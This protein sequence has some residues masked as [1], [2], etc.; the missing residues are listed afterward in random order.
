[1]RVWL[2]PAL[3]AGAGLL[4]LGWAQLSGVARENQLLQL[5]NLGK[6]FYEN[7]TTQAQAVGEFRKALAL[8]PNSPVER[9]NYALSLLRAGK[10]ADGI[11]ELEKVQKQDPG[12]P[13]TWFN[14]GL[15]YK[16]SG[17]HDKSI[18]QFEG[19][20]KLVP[21]EPVSHYNLGV[22]YKVTGRIPEALAQFETALRLDGNLAA[23]HFQLYNAY[24]QSG[25][26]EEAARELQAFQSIKKRTEGAA[27]P[28]DMEWSAYAEILDVIEPRTSL[29]AAPPADLKFED[30]KLAGTADPVTAQ[31]A[32]FDLDGN[33]KPSLMIW[34]SQGIRVYRNGTEV[35]EQPALAG[36]K[37]VN[38][39][40]AGDFDNDGFPDLAVIADGKP[41]LFKNVKG[42]FQRFEANLP[43]G[44]YSQALWLDYDH[45]YDQ[46]LI[47][48]GDN[49]TV[50]RNEGSNAFSE[51]P[52]D[53]PFVKGK[54]IAGATFRLIADT[55][56]TD[57]LVSYADRPGALYRDLLQGVFKEQDVASLPS[58]AR[59][60]RPYDFDNDSYIDVAFLNG[61]EVKTLANR[62]GTLEAGAAT[63]RGGGFVFADLE[64]KGLADLVT[65][66]GVSRNSGMGRFSASQPRFGHGVAWT[67]ADFD[68]DDRIDLAGVYADG[69]I[70]LL[71]NTTVTRNTWIRVRIDG[72]K[73]TKLAA[74]AEVE[75]KAGP[76]YQKILYDGMPLLFGLRDVKEAETVRI[77]WPNGLIQNEA[78]Q[79]AGKAYDYK[80]A[81]RLSGSC[82]II[83]TWNGTGFEYITDVLGVAPL[84][85]SNGDGQ[86]FPVDHQEYV[87]IAGSQLRPEGGWYQVR[88]TEELSEASYIDQVR[89]LAIDHPANVDI[90][91]NDK[92]TG[93]PPWPEFRLWGTKSR[94]YPK[95]ARDDSGNDVRPKLLAKDRTYPDAF[96]RS[97]AGAAELHSLE[98]DFGRQAAPRG[99]AILVMNGWVDWA[100][101]ST[102]LAMAQEKRGGLAPPYLQVRDGKGEW[103]TVIPN[104]G[105][106]DG[107]PKTIVV[108]LSGKWLSDSREVRIVTNLC[109]YWDEIFLSEDTGTPEVRRTD[110]DASGAE[111]RFRGFSANKV[112]PERKQPEQFFYADSSP[113]SL[114]NPTPGL[115][116]R[117]GDVR[118]LLTAVDDRFVIMG[119]GD[120]IRMRFDASRLPALPAGWKRDFLLK[121]DGWAKDRDANTAYSQTVE[122]LPF[123][124]MTRYPYGPDEHYPDDPDHAS[125]RRNYN[126]RPGLQLIRPL[127]GDRT[128]PHRR[129]L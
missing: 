73:N 41:A 28:E 77:T 43:S 114:W 25:R 124:R 80:E 39:V 49:S 96:P 18:R 67:R 91:H 63:V 69:S 31:A 111:V 9:L 120:E 119:S 85:A 29:D 72:V 60:L 97:F 35:V 70:H 121:V 40:A 81:Q 21:D 88:M 38:S 93:E 6:A 47:L 92:W 12:I 113:V 105:M 1:M 11:A 4:L 76:L 84:G 68:G 125:Y 20:I 19:F 116:T 99:D 75:V 8:K 27:I 5:R 52:G 79:A 56:S 13:H 83:W 36:L 90:F 129:G 37:D 23:P 59:D 117:Y 82:P 46:D 14:L 101:G 64:N 15:E 26:R 122:P 104:M 110:L 42:A 62:H 3:S 123:H 33:G 2:L 78:K 89:L 103:Q 87:F 10:T 22:L 50:V 112:H 66:N 98:L 118:E 115:Y 127:V 100:D 7:P 65:A 17:D 109:V 24:R 54:A 95:S 30:R 32:V 48:L 102:F 51:R 94:T 107:K 106:P 45:D 44:P 55:K 53:I 108:D 86:Y 71:R 126:T 58:G 74:G 128:T 61:G 57:L 16:K 34:S